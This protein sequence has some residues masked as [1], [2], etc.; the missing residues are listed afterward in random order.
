MH[1]VKMSQFE[2]KHDPRIYME[3][4]EQYALT[5]K[6]WRFGMVYCSEAEC[7]AHKAAALTYG[8]ADGLDT[9]GG[10]MPYKVA[11]AIGYQNMQKPN[12]QLFIQDLLGVSVMKP[13]E[14]MARIS[15]MASANISELLDVDPSTG[16]A[17]LNLKKAMSRGAMYLVKKL[18]FDTYGNL[19]SI[20]IH[21]SF[22]ALGKMGQHYKLFDRHREAQPDARELA[23]ELLDDLRAKHEEL[24]DHILIEKVLNRFSGSGVTESDLVE[25]APDMNN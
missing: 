9:E 14:V 24:P 25:Q 7:I 2:N 4:K 20:E 21:D 23:R 1:G 18:N 13:N 16:Q 15:K 10:S 3:A 17:T 22:A 19:K 8:K 11:N 5:Y 6:Q 12:I